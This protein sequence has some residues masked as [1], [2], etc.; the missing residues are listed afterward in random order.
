MIVDTD[1]FIAQGTVLWCLGSVH[2][3]VS[4]LV[5]GAVSNVITIVQKIIIIPTEIG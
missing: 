3:N 2:I 5:L 4:V 1:G